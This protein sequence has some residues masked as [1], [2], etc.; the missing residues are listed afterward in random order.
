MDRF[1]EIRYGKH[2]KGKVM[3]R[4]HYDQLAKFI[5]DQLANQSP[6]TL[7]DLLDRAQQQFSSTFNGNLNW[8]LLQVKHELQSRG[9]ITCIT[10]ELSQSIA[11]KKFTLKRTLAIIS[12]TIVD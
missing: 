4:I 2:K 1:V 12:P 3:N 10:K 7:M 9:C 8:S 11:L 5:L 6:I